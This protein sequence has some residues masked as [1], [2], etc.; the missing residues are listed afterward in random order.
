MKMYHA[1]SYENLYSILDEGLVTNNIENIVYLCEKPEEAVRF[2]YIHLVRDIVVFEVE[3]NKKNVIE[4]FDHSEA[5]FKCKA[6]GHKG[7]IPASK[8][9]NVYRY[10]M[11]K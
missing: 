1:T 10:D 8:I 6:F 5:F 2:P 4:T 11:R 3:V 7:N 9:K